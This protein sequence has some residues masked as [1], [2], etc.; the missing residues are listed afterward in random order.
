MLQNNPN[1]D[2]STMIFHSLT[3]TINHR[4]HQK[5]PFTDINLRMFALTKTADT[6]QKKDTCQKNKWLQVEVINVQ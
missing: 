2:K 3:Q 4:G 5:F 1:I 6:C